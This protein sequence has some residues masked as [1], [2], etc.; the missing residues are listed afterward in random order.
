MTEGLRVRVS[1]SASSDLSGTPYGFY[2][3]FQPKEFLKWFL[4]NV[5]LL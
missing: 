2:V 5:D 3:K 1:P 4:N